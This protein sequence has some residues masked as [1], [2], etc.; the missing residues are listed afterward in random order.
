MLDWWG[1]VP[2]F[3]PAALLQRPPRILEYCWGYF[4]DITFSCSPL[5]MSEFGP[6][7]LRS[8]RFCLVWSNQCISLVLSHH[9][10]SFCFYF[11]YNFFYKGRDDTTT[12]MWWLKSATESN[13]HVSA[14]LSHCLSLS[15]SF[16]QPLCWGWNFS[17]IFSVQIGKQSV[18][19]KRTKYLTLAQNIPLRSWNHCVHWVILQPV[20]MLYGSASFSFRPCIISMHCTNQFRPNG[21]ILGFRQLSWLRSAKD[22]SCK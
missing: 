1:M 21:F 5:N 10:G 18:N 17:H 11:Y 19:R 6:G 15:Q 3:L 2:L 9:L 4:S 13:A 8:S 14:C 12:Q 20:I 22:W 16:S 7:P